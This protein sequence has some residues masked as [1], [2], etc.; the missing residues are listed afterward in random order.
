MFL[1][2]PVELGVGVLFDLVAD[3]VE[4]ERAELFNAGNGHRTV[5]AALFAGLLQLVIDF[6]GAENEPLHRARVAGGHAGFGDDAT[7]L[8]R[9]DH[10]VKGRLCVRMA[11]QTLGCED[12]ERFAERH[13]DLATEDVEIVGR[14]RAVGYDHV[15]VVQLADRKFFRFGWERLGVF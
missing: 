5:Q 7:E 13:S 12:N 9:L 3:H 4:R 14:S 10:V 8:G 15:R 11:E 6:A 2:G 1:L